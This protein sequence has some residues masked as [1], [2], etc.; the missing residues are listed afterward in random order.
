MRSAEPLFC[1]TQKRGRALSTITL[2]GAVL[3]VLALAAVSLFIGVA[4]FSLSDLLSG[5]DKAAEVFAISRIP[6]T[7]SLILA[8]TALAVAGLIMQM[9]ARN[10]FVE[11]STAGTVESASLGLLLITL[12]VPNASIF[13]KMSAGSVMALLGTGLFL[14]IL[15]RLPLRNTL[16]VPLIGL[17]LG[18]VIASISTFIAY[19][20]N[21]LQTL[22]AWTT[23]DFSAVLKGR[24]ELLWIVGILT[25]IA[26]IAADRFTVVG[27]GQDFT[28]SLGMS[29]GKIMAIGLTIVAL[30]T[31]VVVV[32]VGA[33]PFLGLIVP[34]LVTLLFGD[35]VRR[36]VPWVAVL[37]AGLVLLCDVVGRII[38]FPAEIPIGLTMGVLGSGLF[39]FLLLW[40]S[41]REY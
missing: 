40:G 15:T 20:S 25:L 4:E 16:F 31:A 5:Q 17:M 18:G 19:G 2:I 7:V 11:P 28:T 21:L 13:L 1:E 29:Y 34:N 41:K 35:N 33:I 27:L 39:L 6:R 23:G 12:A 38:I 9:M 37:G 26:Y 24:Y 32:T 14:L 22:N 3:G 10:K 8:G 30:V 36:G